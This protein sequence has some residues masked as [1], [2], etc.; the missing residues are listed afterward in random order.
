MLKLFVSLLFKLVVLFCL[1][2]DFQD[3]RIFRIK[4]KYYGGFNLENLENP[5]N[6]DS[7]KR[8]VERT[9]RLFLFLKANVGSVSLRSTILRSLI[10]H[11]KLA[12]FRPYHRD[13]AKIVPCQFLLSQI[14]INNHLP[15]H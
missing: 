14:P 7:D 10:L 4:S 12:I 9:L 1:N 11:G 5:V 6:P 13:H 8:C 15:L 2:Q 3:Y